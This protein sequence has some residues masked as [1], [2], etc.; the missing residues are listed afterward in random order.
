MPYSQLSHQLEVHHTYIADIYDAAYYI[1]SALVTVAAPPVAGLY[2]PGQLDPV[3]YADRVY[4]YQQPVFVKSSSQN[5]LTRVN[6]SMYPMNWFQ[7]E[8]THPHN[9][10]WQYYRYNYIRVTNLEQVATTPF[11]VVEM[12]HNFMPPYYNEADETS[13][14]HEQ[15]RKV[16]LPRHLAQ[17]TTLHPQIPVNGIRLCKIV[18]ENDIAATRSFNTLPSRTIEELV[19]PFIS[20]EYLPVTLSDS[21][22]IEHLRNDPW[23]QRTLTGIFDTLL[24]VVS[25][26]R[27]MLRN[28]PYAMFTVNYDNGF[29]IRIDQLGDHRIHEWER[30]VNDPD[31]QRWLRAR[32]DGSWDRF[33]SEQDANQARS[34]AYDLQSYRR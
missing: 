32:A 23:F 2:L 16:V 31:Y 29:N 25:P 19:L 17:S 3:L 30:T 9:Q 14:T 11:D 10:P 34:Y 1:D 26:V 5:V 27:N 33:V 18:L 13:G 6:E 20:E 7:G 21:Q 8:L 4:W 22:K 24:P 12:D 28:T 15:P